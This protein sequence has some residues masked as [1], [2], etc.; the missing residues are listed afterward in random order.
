MDQGKS[1][2]S[3]RFVFNIIEGQD[4]QLRC[5]SLLFC[6]F[7]QFN[8]NIAVVH[9]PVR[10]RDIDELYFKGAIEL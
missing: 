4:L 6:K 1:I 8:I 5:H 7:K 3:N 9:Y 10:Q 2:T